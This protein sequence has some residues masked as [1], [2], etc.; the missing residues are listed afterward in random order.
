MGKDQNEH[1]TMSYAFKKDRIKIIY[2]LFRILCDHNQKSHD[3]V[4]LANFWS[5]QTSRIL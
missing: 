3:R 5:K 4:M 1:I 2:V